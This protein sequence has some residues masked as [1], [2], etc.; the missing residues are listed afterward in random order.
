M[1]PQS[2]YTPLRSALE[3]IPRFTWH[4]PTA[5]V[6]NID[7]AFSPPIVAGAPQA[8]PTVSV[9]PRF[10]PIPQSSSV[11]PLTRDSVMLRPPP[12]PGSIASFPCTPQSS[13]RATTSHFAAV[14]LWGPG[15][16][17][18]RDEAPCLV[19]LP[20]PE[21]GGVTDVHFYTGAIP[22]ETPLAM[23]WRPNGSLIS[24]SSSGS[25]R[26]TATAKVMINTSFHGAN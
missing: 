13:I 22:G 7:P 25:A 21:D 18:R 6:P 19:S 3:E 2:G 12:A 4:N 10:P 23:K 24:T 8:R 15:P 20:P 17:D 5:C 9:S 1:I 16:V 14:P 11:H 26:H